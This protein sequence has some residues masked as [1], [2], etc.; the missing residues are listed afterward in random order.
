MPFCFC[1]L[2]FFQW[3][4]PNINGT[5]LRMLIAT[6]TDKL[7][8]LKLGTFL[9]Y[10][11]GKI[12][13]ILQFNRILLCR[14]ET[15]NFI[16]NEE[17]LIC[18]KVNTCFYWNW[19]LGPRNW[20]SIKLCKCWVYLELQEHLERIRNFLLRDWNIDI[21]LEFCCNLQLLDIFRNIL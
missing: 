16:L 18:Y 3:K 6:I 17:K 13:A 12:F 11:K 5:V 21:L 8:L 7:Y 20:R 15:V 19:N 4:A 1:D 2:F 9:E 14:R 10:G